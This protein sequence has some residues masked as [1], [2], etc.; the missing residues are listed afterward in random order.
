MLPLGI[1]HLQLF[2]LVPLGASSSKFSRLLKFPALS[3]ED[4]EMGFAWQW[5]D[6]D[7]DTLGPAG[8]EGG[9][10]PAN[11]SASFLGI[12]RVTHR[13]HKFAPGAIRAREPRLWE[14]LKSC[15]DHNP[16]SEARYYDNLQV[17]E[18]L[19]RLVDDISAAASGS[20]L[21]GR[22]RDALSL[23]SREPYSQAFVLKSDWFRLAVVYLEGGWWVDG[24]VRCIDPIDSV[25]AWEEPMGRA[26]NEALRKEGGGSR[27]PST[28]ACVFAW[29]GELP[30]QPSAPLN[31][32]FGCPPRHPFLLHAMGELSDRVMRMTPHADPGGG[33]RAAVSLPSGESLYLDVLSTTGP[34]MVGEALQSYGNP[35]ESLKAVRER[36]G[37][38]EG[39]KETWDRVSIVSRHGKVEHVDGSTDTSSSSSVVVLPYCFF[40]GRGCGHLDRRFSDMVIF[41]HEFDTSWR[42]SYWHNYFRPSASIV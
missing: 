5:E 29:E 6:M 17:D 30:L 36:Y 38:R 35:A 25:L 7:T 4:G 42:R 23:I 28:E 10:A 1:V 34:G 19:H 3:I 33:F 26:L 20:P 39:D 11:H 22:M 24:D 14:N 13:S 16:G 31:W 8:P 40:R 21:G 41:H 12:P 27:S 18:V 9:H 37:E 2:L 32:A 15:V